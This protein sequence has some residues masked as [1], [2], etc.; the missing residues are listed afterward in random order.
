[1]ATLDSATTAHDP[2]PPSANFQRVRVINLRRRGDRRAETTSELAELG[3]TVDGERLSFFEAIEPDLAAGFPS[4]GVRGCYLSHL[5]VLEAAAGDGVENLLVMEDDVA[6][7]RDARR[8]PWPVHR[9][10]RDGSLWT[11]RCATRTATP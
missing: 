9:E 7:I 6:F 5:G 10:R 2:A 4:P 1:M 3:E 11:A 8:L